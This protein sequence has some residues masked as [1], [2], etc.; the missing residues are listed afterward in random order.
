MVNEMRNQMDIE[1]G[2]LAKNGQGS[3]RVAVGEFVRQARNTVALAR[4]VP[5]LV[6]SF[7][8][9]PVPR[10]RDLST[11][12]AL[13]LDVLSGMYAQERKALVARQ[14]P[15]AATLQLTLAGLETATSCLVS[16][17]ETY[18]AQAQAT[19][20]RLPV[21]PA[22][23]PFDGPAMG[24]P[25]ITRDLS[26]RQARRLAGSMR[27]LLDTA[28]ADLAY[29]RESL[30][31]VRDADLFVLASA[32]N[33]LRVLAGQLLRRENDLRARLYRGM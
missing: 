21:I 2:M 18:A 23:A 7:R 30:E 13:R 12:L 24:A 33:R 5:Q 32:I 20:P 17:V 14:Q 27:A 6:E 22:S 25:E 11:E 31:G 19:N 16:L 15:S 29:V 26:K 1:S 3:G 10:T 9:L 8:S 28:L 4:A